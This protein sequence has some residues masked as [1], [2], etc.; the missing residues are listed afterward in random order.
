MK[1]VRILVLVLSMCLL[2]CACAPVVTVTD[3]NA[4]IDMKDRTFIQAGVKYVGT[5][6]D[7]DAAEIKNW[8]DFVALEGTDL[9]GNEG[10]SILEDPLAKD[11]VTLYENGD[12]IFFVSYNIVGLKRTTFTKQSVNV[13]N[14]KPVVNIVN[15]KAELVKNNFAIVQVGVTY[16]GE[17]SSVDVTKITNWG[18]FVEANDKALNGKPGFTILTSEQVETGVELADKGDYIFYVNYKAADDT[19]RTVYYKVTQQ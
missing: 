2:L 11:G 3:D 15:G 18:A 14:S 16:V 19:T 7:A 6:S 4:A 1:R 9:N 12:Y 8:D 10:F 5:I 13:A 17:N